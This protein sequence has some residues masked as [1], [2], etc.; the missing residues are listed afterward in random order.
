M[1]RFW[2]IW[3]SVTLAFGANAQTDTLPGRA[4]AGRATTGRAT[5][6]R[7]IS[8]GV[9]VFKNAY[10]QLARLAPAPNG[11]TLLGGF[12]PGWFFTVE[13][14][15]RIETGE[16]V[17]NVAPVGGWPRRL[18]WHIE[19]GYTGFGNVL[20][21]RNIRLDQQGGFLKVGRE[22]RHQNISATLLLVLAGWQ[23]SGRYVLPGT[24]FGPFEGT[25]PSANHFTM[26]VEGQIAGSVPLG[27]RSALRIAFRLN[28]LLPFDRN[29]VGNVDEFRTPYVP[30]VG[31]ITQNRWPLSAGIGFQ[32]EYRLRPRRL[33]NQS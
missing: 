28:A 8:L 24:T 9:D 17:G 22:R 18:F 10:A 11:P 23:Q 4:T 5:T 26:G 29:S 15:I 7:E 2:L 19:G 13:P 25:I 27:E 6:G 33:A 31:F 20:T 12:Q 1:K 3:L 30:G 16:S 21:Q 14:M 32:Y